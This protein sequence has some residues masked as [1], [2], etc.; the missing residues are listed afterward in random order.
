MNYYL[1]CSGWSYNHWIDIF[2][3]SNLER[4][5]WLIF[6]S[7]HFNSVEVNATFYRFPFTNVVKGWYNKTPRDFNLTLKANRQITHVKKL[8]NV[9]SLL[10]SFY[11]YADLLKEKLGCILFQVH[12]F[13]K[14][15]V[16][17]LEDFVN[18]LDKTKKNVIEF[19]NTSWYDKEVYKI[20]EKNNIGFCIVSAPKLPEE[21]ISTTDFGYV[22]FHGKDSWYNYNYSKR[23]MSDW[24]EKI[25]K[26]DVE[27]VFVYFN[28]DFNAYAVENCQQLYSLLK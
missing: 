26:L 17:L 14:K 21:V 27:D 16:K 20:L 8:K 6:Y 11:K 25:K 4:R 7:K 1:G 13:L 2:Y 19:R 15:N 18:K 3:P 10:E 22:R 28:N 9:D 5:E 12:P 23:E 24:A